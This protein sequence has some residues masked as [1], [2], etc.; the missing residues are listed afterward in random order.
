M[1]DNSESRNIF[2]GQG[3][4]Q[5]SAVVGTVRSPSAAGPIANPPPVAP[6]TSTQNEEIKIVGKRRNSSNR[7]MA[8]IPLQF[9]STRIISWKMDRIQ[10]NTALLFVMET[11]RSKHIKFFL[12]RAG[13]DI[14]STDSDGDT[15]LA[16]ALMRNKLHFAAASLCQ[17]RRFCIVQIF[18][19]QRSRICL[20]HVQGHLQIVKLL[21]EEGNANIEVA[22]SDGN[23]ALI[24]AL[25]K[26][27]FEIA[28]YLCD[29][30]ARIDRPNN[31]VA[32]PCAVGV[33]ALGLELQ[34]GRANG[35]HWGRN[36]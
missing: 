6:A 10:M 28:Q 31:D 30:G 9:N 2:D 7:S 11:E 13:A 35:E 1:A 27:N 16:Y 36:S 8:P 33:L 4:R 19:R 14:E 26:R 34:I 17:K 29:K 24:L 18:G 23:T 15:A 32:R 25:N 5:N 22:N 3:G 12:E 20:L 21:V